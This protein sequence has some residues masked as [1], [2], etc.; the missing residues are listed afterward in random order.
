MFLWGCQPLLASRRGQS[1][2]YQLW[3]SHS[4]FP[5]HSRLAGSMRGPPC[6]SHAAIGSRRGLPVPSDV[7]LHR[8]VPVAEGCECG[9]SYLCG[10]P[11]FSVGTVVW[12]TAFLRSLPC[13]GSPV[14]LL[15]TCVCI[16]FEQEH[17]APV[18]VL[19]F[20]CSQLFSLLG[21]PPPF[22]KGTDSVES[23]WQFLPVFAFSP[24]TSCQS[25]GSCL[26]T[27]GGLACSSSA[28]SGILLLGL[29]KIFIFAD[30]FFMFWKLEREGSK[31]N[32]YY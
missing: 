2:W 31:R 17:F 14:P 24:L 4:S 12:R 28:L 26:L 30:F 29:R 11:G 23:E 16:S 19:L 27:W 13:S 10:E 1:Q 18:D 5:P 25:P 32:H 22:L 15:G 9:L 6:L 7:P 20:N 3:L 8:F 21:S